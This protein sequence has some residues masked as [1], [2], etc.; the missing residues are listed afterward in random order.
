MPGPRYIRRVSR[1]ASAARLALVLVLLTS[2]Q[3][4]AVIE[5]SFALNR[6]AIAARY[7]VNRARPELHCDGRCELARRLDAQN[8]REQDR[9]AT[10]LGVALSASMWLPATADLR[11]PA[12]RRT[13]GYARPADERVTPAS[14]AG[15][16]H[17][18][19]AA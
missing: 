2:L 6:D 4:Y 3:S 15:V 11:P 10:L 8:R 12:S 5:A 1:F 9:E 17:P 14:P 18:P 19:R 7:C 16:F 13:A